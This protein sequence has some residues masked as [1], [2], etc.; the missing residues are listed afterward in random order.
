MQ[1]GWLWMVPGEMACHHMAMAACVIRFFLSN[2]SLLLF[3]LNCNAYINL[4]ALDELS[5]R[6]LIR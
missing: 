2:F 1:N 4:K 6:N 5:L 3:L